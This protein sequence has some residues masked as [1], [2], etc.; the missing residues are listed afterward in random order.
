MVRAQ[1]INYDLN[2]LNSGF[3]NSLEFG[4]KTRLLTDMTNL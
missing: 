3:I 4:V 2:L 1:Y